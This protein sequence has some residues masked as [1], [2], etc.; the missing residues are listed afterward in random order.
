MYA[1]VQTG[2]KQYK[3]APGDVIVVEK[4]PAEVG[5]TVTLDQVHLVRQDDGL[6]VGTPT[7]PGVRVTAQVLEHGRGKK[8]IV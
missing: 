1:I 7:V 8:I 6:R 5:Q 2:G 3:V 4:L